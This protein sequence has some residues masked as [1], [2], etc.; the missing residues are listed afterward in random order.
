MRDRIR[1]PIAL[2]I[3]GFAILVAF[4]FATISLFSAE[5]IGHCI[6]TSLITIAC[7]IVFYSLQPKFSDRSSVHAALLLMAIVTVYWVMALI[8][9][10]S[11]VFDWFSV[12]QWRTI[13]G[14]M[15][16]GILPLLFMVAACI[17]I[18]RPNW[19][20]MGWVM[21]IGF[22]GVLILVQWIQW[23]DLEEENARNA[24]WVALLLIGVTLVSG[25]LQDPSRIP[26]YVRQAIV[27]LV[28]VSSFL[29]GRLVLL[30]LYPDPMI[31]SRDDVD[32]FLW[33]QLFFLIAYGL[34]IFFAIFSAIS[35]RHLAKADWLRWCTLGS[36]LVTIVFGIL[37][38]Y[39]LIGQ[40]LILST[41]S[42]FSEDNQGWLLLYSKP[43][44]HGRIS[45]AFL[46]I[47]FALFLMIGFVSRSG[48]KIIQSAGNW[49]IADAE[50]SSIY[51]RM[52]KLLEE[53]SSNRR[54]PFHTPV[55]ATRTSSGDPDLRTVVLRRVDRD[56]RL[57]CCHTDSRSPKV[58]EI[59]KSGR[60]A[61]LFYDPETRVQV[62][63]N[64]H[65]RIHAGPDDAIA[66]E[67]WRKVQ[68]DSRVCYSAPCAPSLELDQWESNQAANAREIAS[69]P[70]SSEDMPPDSFAVL[71]TVLD[72]IE[73]LELHHDGHRRIRFRVDHDGKPMAQW[74]AP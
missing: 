13:A 64:G 18:K 9:I 59:R 26:W 40:E 51:D 36:L 31:A 10:W 47:T 54:H 14:S 43:I 68:P 58:G 62:R 19:T 30:D 66:C 39:G 61:W 37:S 8:L 34:G 25:A 32:S 57:V 48:S 52:W 63:A 29:I 17:V 35:R 45:I 7:A 41:S 72:S 46:L 21:L 70:I 69:A 23:G 71:A 5:H 53:G 55:M 42:A 1:H 73:W 65:C 38:I 74:L 44:I 28:V 2:F 20:R 24:S 50:G 60:V 3:Y 4:V 11:D 22:A 67:T 27:L 56:G 33:Q 12:S 15:S 6:G 49:S 16:G